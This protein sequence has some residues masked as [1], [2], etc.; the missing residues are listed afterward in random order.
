M[1][2]SYFYALKW[3]TW[4]FEQNQSRQLDVE[5]SG[6]AA[7]K[8]AEEFEGKSEEGEE[9]I[10]REETREATKI[11]MKNEDHFPEISGEFYRLFDLL[12]A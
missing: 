5:D 6:R 8:L 3:Y 11:R 4:V 9:G 12:D 7:S 1:N 10:D 2:L